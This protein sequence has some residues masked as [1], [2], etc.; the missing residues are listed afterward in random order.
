ME[1][2]KDILS[3]SL[4]IVLVLML[5]LQQ[6]SIKKL[7]QKSSVI[8]PDSSI[9]I[10]NNFYDSAAKVIKVQLPPLAA[11]SIFVDV[12]LNVDTAAILQRYFNKYAYSQTFSDSSL[13]AFITDTISQNKIIARSFTYQWLKPVKIENKT[14]NIYTAKKN[15]FLLGAQ[16]HYVNNTIQLVPQAAWFYNQKIMISAGSSLLAPQP[17]IMIGTLIRIGNE[18]RNNKK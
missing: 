9:T 3:L 4:F 16:T 6:C 18:K 10:T 15:L 8:K 11:E 17:N 13:K 12:P 14:E 2:L 5:C 7:Q 1:K